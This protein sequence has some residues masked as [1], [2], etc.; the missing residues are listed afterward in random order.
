M[1]KSLFLKIYLL[2][3]FLLILCGMI[4]LYLNLRMHYI[5]YKHLTDLRVRYISKS[6][7]EIIE[8]TLN[9]GL[10]LN[11]IAGLDKKF[12]DVIEMNEDIDFI[13]LTDNQFDIIVQGIDIKSEY[14]EDFEIADK[15]FKSIFLFHID[16]KKDILQKFEDDVIPDYFKI[17]RDDAGVTYIFPIK[18]P[19]NE[20]ECFYVI[21]FNQSF[22]YKDLRKITFSNFIIGIVVFAIFYMLLFVILKK[23]LN[24]PLRLIS[25]QIIDIIDNNDY[26]KRIKGRVPLELE[27]FKSSFNKLLSFTEKAQKQLHDV[28][29][30]LKLDI[31]E[32][33]KKLVAA[34]KQLKELDKVK[35]EFLS[36]ISH[37]IRTP[38]TSIKA[39]T[40][41]IIDEIYENE[42]EKKD[43]LNVIINE[44]DKLTKLVSELLDISKLEAGKMQFDMKYF[45]FNKLIL[46][47]SSIYYKLYE[48][49]KINFVLKHKLEN[50]KIFGD[51][52]RM[53]QVISNILNNAFKFTPVNGEVVLKT[54]FLSK[55]EKFNNYLFLIDTIF[56]SISDTGD[57]IKPEEEEK[58]WKKFSQAGKS[59]HDGAGLGLTISKEIILKHKGVIDFVR[60]SNNGSTF[61]IILPINE[62]KIKENVLY[63]KI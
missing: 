57:G 54:G 5:Q 10:K 45:D 44:A 7:I 59:F 9:F 51:Y 31:I 36:I 18:N 41:S 28:N 3:G 39:Y 11:E 34:N 30:S 21:G 43:F 61:F 29:V 17:D 1:K 38:L 24:T 27:E 8:K 16:K 63:K 15:D 62:T 53:Y 33:N 52:S 12:K 56:I 55:N 20:I 50:I 26:S 48:K 35:D 47:I 42:T 19:S 2:L 46:E 60:N 23:Y 14:D 6:N 25:N 40:E 37:E 32:H 4:L 22:I 58:I 49:K 13:Y